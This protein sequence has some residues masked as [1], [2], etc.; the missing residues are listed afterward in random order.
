LGS[1]AI[2]LATLAASAW[3]P[4]TVS[5]QQAESTH[6]PGHRVA[7]IDVAYLFK[8]L[9]EIKAQVGKFESDLKKFDAEVKQQR[10][11]LKQSAAELQT[12]RNGTADYARKEEKIANLESK[13]RLEMSRKQQ[14]FRDAEARIYYENYQRIAAAVKAIATH[15]NIQLVLRFNS[16]Q[17][18]LEQNESVARGVMKNVV[19][20]QSTIDMTQTVMRYLEHQANRSQIAT[21]GKPASASKR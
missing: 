8:N 21:G 18:A 10:E 4:V 20:H 9:P 14:E 11:T 15:N 7:V 19:Y 6:Q 13:L 5:A 2:A 16:E 3:A 1:A 17:M 12:L